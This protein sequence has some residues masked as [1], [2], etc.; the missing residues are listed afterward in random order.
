ME[1]KDL[2]NLSKEPDSIF[3][4]EDFDIGIY[5]KHI[6]Q[7]RNAIFVTAGV[8]LLSLIVTLIASSKEENE[9]L[10][11]DLLL[12]GAFIIGFIALGFWTKNRPYYAIICALI[13]YLIFIGLNAIGDIKTLFSGIIFKILI[14]VYLVKGINDAKAAEEMRQ[15]RK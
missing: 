15:L 5:D 8:I 4:E 9:Y 6:R 12:Y 3:T 13:L 10:W 2:Q 14:I 1:D 11:I 7:A